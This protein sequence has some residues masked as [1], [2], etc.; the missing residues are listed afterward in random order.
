MGA[1]YGGRIG[2]R[3]G[4]TYGSKMESSNRSALEKNIEWLMTEMGL[5][6]DEAIE[7]VL[8]SFRRS[9][10]PSEPLE[11]SEDMIA[12]MKSRV[13]PSQIKENPFDIKVPN[14]DPGFERP[15]RGENIDPGFEVGIE[16]LRGIR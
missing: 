13:H 11:L 2:F 14:I 6:R 8:S 3:Y 10:T 7:R 9:E 4:K 5:S 15:W 16:T 1:E 12:D